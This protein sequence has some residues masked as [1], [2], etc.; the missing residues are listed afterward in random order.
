MPSPDQEL[1]LVFPLQGM[2]I[3]TEFE[4]QPPGTTV[5]A[6]NVRSIEPG[7]QRN[8]G[9][10]RCGIRKYVDQKL[11]LHSLI[12]HINIIVD[13]TVDATLSVDE[14]IRRFEDGTGIPDPGSVINGSTTRYVRKGG[15][16]VQPKRRK[17]P[18]KAV[19]DTI[20]ATVGGASVDLFPTDNDT[21]SGSPTVTLGK[22]PN[23]RGGTIALSGP[24]GGWKVTY[25]P[26]ATGSGGTFIVPYR[27]TA[28]GNTGPAYANITITA[29][30]GGRIPNGDYPV[31]ITTMNPGD[32]SFLITIASGS[33]LP[34]LT[35]EYFS[36]FGDPATIQ[37]AAE[38]AAA[39]GIIFI[40]TDVLNF[41]SLG[42]GVVRITGDYSAAGP[43]GPGYTGDMNP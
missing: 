42:A 8:R 17:D 1:E 41:P 13:P 40:V 21:Y 25:T 20:T 29:S 33:S 19:N 7:Q 15:S 36:S 16:G 24:I 27:L 2:D 6:Q 5:F 4:L 30:P 3:T 12:Q 38:A 23:L 10:A 28:P 37:A 31:T 34:S 9:G 18:P 22:V 35:I 39:G 11:G 32:G 43:T 14:D 26:P